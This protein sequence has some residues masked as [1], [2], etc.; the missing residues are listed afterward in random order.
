[1]TFSCLANYLEK[2][3]KTSSRLEMTAMLAEV[4]NKAQKEEIDKICY[5]VLGKLAP[6]YEGLEFNLAEKMML[7]AIAQTVGKNISQVTKL[8]KQNGDLMG[9]ARLEPRTAV[10]PV[11]QGWI[12]RGSVP[13]RVALNNP[14]PFHP[15]CPHSWDITPKRVAKSECSLLWM[16]E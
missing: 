16:G 11:C 13:V 15:S 3:E 8:Y 2:L 14:S 9:T 10:C 5:L 12:A 6:E 4:F 1:M 7:R